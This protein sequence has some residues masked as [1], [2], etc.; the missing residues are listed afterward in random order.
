MSNLEPVRRL[1]AVPDG[2]APET[3]TDYC[4]IS[5]CIEKVRRQA[6]AVALGIEAR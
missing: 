1:R 4:S 6:R 5:R 3:A 2:W